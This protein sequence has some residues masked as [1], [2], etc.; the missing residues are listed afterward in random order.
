MMN[1]YEYYLNNMDNTFDRN[2]EYKIENDPYAAFIK[3]NSFKN[4]YNQYKNYKP[5]DINPKNEREYLLLLIQ[6]YDFVA[7][8]LG[9]YLDVNPNNSN[10]IQLRNK[11]IKLHN[12]VLMQYK[13]KYGSLSLD[14]N[15]SDKTPWS[16]DNNNFPWEV[17]K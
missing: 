7:H 15:I 5:I 10:V 14:N 3:G 8:D 11:Y 17:D 4:L 1:D 9:L 16:W 2:N 13:N 12:Q 6:I